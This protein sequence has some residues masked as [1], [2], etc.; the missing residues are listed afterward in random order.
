MYRLPE[1]F[2]RAKDPVGAALDPSADRRVTQFQVRRAKTIVASI[3][4]VA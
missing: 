4:I 1:G 2:C 3:A